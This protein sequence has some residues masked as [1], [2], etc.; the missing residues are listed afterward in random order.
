[1]YAPFDQ[2]RA[3]S[4][5]DAAA[6]TIPPSHQIVM[7]L[8]GAIR[9]TRLA[10]QAIVDRCP[11]QRHQA[12]VKAHDIVQ[13]LHSCLDL[14]KGGEVA[15]SLDRVYGYLSSRMMRVDIENSTRLCDEIVARLG[16]L[17]TAWAALAA[18]PSTQS[19]TPIAP[20]SAAGHGPL[21]QAPRGAA[22]QV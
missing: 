18:K 16:E 1:M 7:L 5:Y 12:V 4:A 8:D 3:R 6:S 11:E 13:A 9:F 20:T 19:P 2:Q 15:R 17:R 14:D 22:L 10:R 21:P